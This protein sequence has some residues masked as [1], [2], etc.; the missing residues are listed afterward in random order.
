MTGTNLKNFINALKYFENETNKKDN[1]FI[2][3]YSIKNVSSTITKIIIGY[4]NFVN[5]NNYKKNIL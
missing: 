2:S 1:K 5:Q 3:S 4:I